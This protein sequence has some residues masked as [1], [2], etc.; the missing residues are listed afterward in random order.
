M[1]FRFLFVSNFIEEKGILVTIEAFKR[2]KGNFELLLVGGDPGGLF[3]EEIIR[4]DTRIKLLG[5]MDS[6]R[7]THYLKTSDCLVFPTFYPKETFGLVVIEAWREGL[8][9]ITTLH[10]GLKH[11]IRDRANALVVKTNDSEDLTRRMFELYQ[12]TDLC[13]RLSVNG[14][15]EY[16]NRFNIT[17]FHSRMKSILL[18]EE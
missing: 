17:E 12:D 18:N 15:K 8:P 6:I 3:I 2:L 1:A 13:K 11:Y 5:K 10:N 14:N 4:A 9:V 16:N 7:V